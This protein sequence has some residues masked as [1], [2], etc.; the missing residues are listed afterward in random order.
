MFLYPEE[1]KGW[2][3]RERKRGRKEEEERGREGG[4]KKK[5]REEEREHAPIFLF[6]PSQTGPEPGGQQLFPG[7]LHV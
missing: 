3:K 4:K 7:L 2:R 1:G 6:T 5:R